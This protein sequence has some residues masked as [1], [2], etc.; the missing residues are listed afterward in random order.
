MCCNLYMQTIKH[1]TSQH[2]ITL[3]KTFQY[4]CIMTLHIL[5]LID[6]TIHMFIRWCRGN[7]THFVSSSVHVGWDVSVVDI[8]YSCMDLLHLSQDVKACTSQLVVGWIE[9]RWF[10]VFCFACKKYNTQTTDI[11]SVNNKLQCWYC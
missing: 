10:Q 11:I 7:V 6:N 5:S 9:P 4:T 3:C 2:S 8:A 1:V